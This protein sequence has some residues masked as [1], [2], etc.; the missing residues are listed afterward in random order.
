MNEERLFK[1]LLAPYI[2]EKGALTTGQ[3]VFELIPEATKPEIKRAIEKQFNV[4]VKSV[5]TC[6]V[7]GK[8]TRFRQVRGRR[9]N[10]KKAYVMLAPGSEIDIAAGE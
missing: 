6:N 5:R 9:K 10:W 2:S 1:I 4:T 3:Y 8:T 7:K